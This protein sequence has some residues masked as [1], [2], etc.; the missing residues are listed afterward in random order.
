MSNTNFECEC[1]Y[2]GRSKTR[3]DKHLKTIKHEVLMKCGNKKLWDSIIILRRRI[4]M[5][6]HKL[7]L[8]DIDE[9]I[10]YWT[11]DPEEEDKDQFIAYRNKLN[12][13]IDRWKLDRKIIL[14]KNE[15]E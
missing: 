5:L 9:E 13:I 10:G 8:D 12:E 1:G 6:K 4:R 2:I 3:Y 11:T 15:H 7:K 14:S